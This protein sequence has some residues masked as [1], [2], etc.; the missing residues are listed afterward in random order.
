[1]KQFQ[2]QMQAKM[3]EFSQLIT[4]VNPPR[5][6]RHR[7][8]KGSEESEVEKQNHNFDNQRIWELGN[9]IDIPDFASR[10]LPGES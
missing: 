7:G 9:K 1:M 10:L 8:S 6:P 2:T 3:Q 5:H 4:A